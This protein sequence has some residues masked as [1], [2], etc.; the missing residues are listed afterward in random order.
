[1]RKAFSYLLLLPVVGIHFWLLWNASLFILVYTKR[2]MWPLDIQRNDDNENAIKI[3]LVYQSQSEL[4]HLKKQFSFLEQTFGRINIKAIGIWKALDSELDFSKTK[5]AG[6]FWNLFYTEI[7][8]IYFK[9]IKVLLPEFSKDL[10]SRNGI[11]ICSMHE[12]FHSDERINIVGFSRGFPFSHVILSMTSG[13][14]VM[15]HE[16]GHSCGLWHSKDKNNLMFPLTPDAPVIVNERQKKTI[17][18]ARYIR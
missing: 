11:I 14:H 7:Y 3:L 16:V 5:K 2:L 12:R 4:E 9:Y 15:A 10:L 17:L 13:Q 18:M 8:L 6:L 1:L